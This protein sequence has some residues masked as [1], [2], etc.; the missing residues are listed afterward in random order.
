[1]K[2]LI[3]VLNAAFSVPAFM[4]ITGDYSMTQ[5][6]VAYVAGMCCVWIFVFSMS[7]LYRNHKNT[8]DNICIVLR[9]L[10][11]VIFAVCLLTVGFSAN[12]YV[13]A[14]GYFMVLT[15]WASYCIKPKKPNYVNPIK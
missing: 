3:T 7:R 1:M 12:R 2:N 6:T 15:A 13:M 14:W 11:W 9:A 10:S 8:V 5:L 4:L